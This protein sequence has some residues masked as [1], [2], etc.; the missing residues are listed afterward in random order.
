MKNRTWNI[1]D[2]D[3][4]Y[5][6]L[7]TDNNLSAI[8]GP[9]HD[10][11]NR[12]YNMMCAGLQWK[13][14]W[15]EQLEAE[16]R[17][18]NAY[19]LLR[20]VVNSILA[21]ELA[22]RKKIIA[23]PSGRGGDVKLAE[24]VTQVLLHFFNRT[25][26][27]WH[28][29]K[30]QLDAI[31]AKYGVYNVGWSYEKD[32]LGELEI[33]AIDPRRIK[34]ELNYADPSWSKA[35]YIYDKH[36]LS[37]EE[38]LNKYALDDD[39]MQNTILEE[40]KMFFEQD[41]DKKSKWVSKRLKA[42]FSAAYEIVTSGNQS[43][44]SNIYNKYL[45]WFDPITGK[46][47]VL[48]L[49]E[50]RTERRLLVFD[51]NRQK[52]IDITEQ[53]KKE[54]G[55]GFDNEKIDQVKQLYQ[56]DGEP[57]T[58]LD[59][60]RFI[61]AVIPAFRLKV[62][63]QPYPWDIDYYT[64]IPN[65]CYDYHADAFKAQSVIDDLVDPQS[66]FNKARSTKLELLTRYVN[67]G[68]VGDENAIVGVEEDWRT[69]EIT[70]FRRIRSGYFG[71]VKPEEGQTISNDLVRET[72]EAPMLI[73][74]ISNA[75]DSIRGSQQ[76][77]NESG[78]RTSIRI[79][80]Q[81][82]SFSY[83]FANNDNSAIAVAEVSFGIIQKMVTIPRIIRITQDLPNGQQYQDV[84]INQPQ[85]AIEPESGKLV[86]QIKND[87]T[88]GK[89]DFTMDKAAYSSNAKEIEFAMISDL[90]DAV[91]ETNLKKAD[92]M[93]PILVEVG[94]FP[95]AEKI[96][97][98]WAKVEE[99]TPEQQQMEQ[100]MQQMALQ[101]QQIMAK[102]DIASKEEDLKGKRL[103]NAK[104]LKELRQPTVMNPKEPITHANVLRQKRP[105]TQL[106]ESQRN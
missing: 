46:F 76:N 49:H 45:N 1:H 85:Y 65:Y 27:D 86:T 51:R 75:R 98:A 20:P 54:L 44:E 67:K 17:P 97:A 48:E 81:E 7:R 33:T 32:P 95:A 8:F 40:A 30:V 19:N 29:T 4:L 99:G 77:A 83:L 61:T 101:L 79:N 11:M 80:Q 92:A 102:L 56:I 13:K 57:R 25:K 22:N 74:Q 6:M 34:F 59:S 53:A 70:P 88:I 62:N 16:G 89:Y 58:T 18:A 47:D 9:L 26:F 93:L 2:D 94:G 5:D 72:S 15:K 100:Q 14:E 10:E 43:T 82:K 42:L 96:L 50:K 90:F 35:S 31:I 3:I 69:N 23:K 73:E 28:R 104:K 105:A 55:L 60:K 84:E 103:D 39:E 106:Q 36:Q 63:E 24:V 87:I 37:L 21:I 66:D 91:K 12:N 52:N 38:I 71:L 41:Q 68:W 78:K 64:Y